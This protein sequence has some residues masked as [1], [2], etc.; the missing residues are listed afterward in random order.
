MLGEKGSNSSSCELF[1]A[2]KCSV[3]LLL[4]TYSVRIDVARGL[5]DLIVVERDGDNGGKSVLLI[6]GLGERVI[7]D[8]P[9][10]INA[11]LQS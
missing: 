11:N 8:L 6:E 7:Q 1:Y 3:L 9:I 2:E 5:E 10:D 4:D